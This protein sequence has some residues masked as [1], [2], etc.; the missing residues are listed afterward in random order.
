MKVLVTGATGFVGRWL[1]RE[2]RSAGHEPVEAPSS[3]RLDLSSHDA[4][5]DLVARSRVDAIAHLAGISF[6]PDAARAPAR[7]TAV[8]VGATTLLVDAARRRGPIPM[9]VTSSAD[10]YGAPDPSDL[11]LRE[12][13][14][15]RAESPYGRSK[16][17]QEQAAISAT[18]GFLPLVIT[19]A[20]NHTGPGQRRVFVAPALTSR[21]LAARATETPK[22]RVGNLDVRRDL[23]DVRDVVRAYRLLLEHL[24]EARPAEPL[25][26]NVASGR[27]TAIRDLL[28]LICRVAEVE[29]EIDVDAAL[30]RQDDPPELVGDASRLHDLTGW[31]PEIPLEQTVRDLVV[32][33]ETPPA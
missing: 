18:E 16:V 21:V 3:K 15:L 30:V 25:I 28:G 29:P 22:V 26:L 8:N 10:V 6:A 32:S 12:D 2:L 20:F 9:L 4:A 19:R 31:A 5:V 33:L 11:P 17:E 23:S 13:A 24:V 1:V 14:P 7:V 27:S